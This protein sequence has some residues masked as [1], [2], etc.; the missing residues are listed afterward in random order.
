MRDHGRLKYKADFSALY[1]DRTLVDKAYVDSLIA[2]ISFIIDAVPT[3]GSGNAVSSNGVFDALAS[4]ATLVN[5]KLQKDQNLSDLVD[6][7]TARANLGLGTM[8]EQDA[9]AVAITG[10]TIDGITI[11]GGTF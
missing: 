11:N 9:N 3:D 1:D 8:A 5:G 4:L 2:A 7:V 10:G 6:I